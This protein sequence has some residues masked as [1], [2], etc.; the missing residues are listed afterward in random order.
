MTGGIKGVITG[1]GAQPSHRLVYSDNMAAQIINFPYLA[2]SVYTGQV[3][4]PSVPLPLPF[5]L[6]RMRARQASV[7]IETRCLDAVSDRRGSEYIEAPQATQATH[8]VHDCDRVRVSSSAV[9]LMADLSEALAHLVTRQ[10]DTTTGSSQ[11]SYSEGNVTSEQ[12]LAMNTRAP[13]SSSA[14][15]LGCE[16]SDCLGRPAALAARLPV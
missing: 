9:N 2:K 15:T 8:R 11:Y 5:F 14:F 6:L 4:I 13:F 3:R 1:T 12:C 7:R 10:P 16:V